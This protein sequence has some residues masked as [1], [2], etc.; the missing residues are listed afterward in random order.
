MIIVILLMRNTIKGLHNIIVD[1]T[2]NNK[3]SR[4]EIL[5]IT[6]FLCMIL[7]LRKT[8]LDKV[9]DFLNIPKHIKKT[10]KKK[11]D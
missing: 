5:D 8:F 9:K 1:Y 11:N 3:M 2:M 4:K 10:P 6:F 7:K